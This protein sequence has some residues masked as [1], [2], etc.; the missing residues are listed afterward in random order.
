MS[1]VV[2]QLDLSAIE[3]MYEE[4]DRVNHHITAHD[5]E[6][7]GVRVLRAQS[8]EVSRYLARASHNRAICKSAS[9]N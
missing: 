9:E 7:P 5:G 3:S 2:D 8:L 4:E 6:D 1:D